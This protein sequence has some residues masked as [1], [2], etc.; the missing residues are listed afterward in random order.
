MLINC[1]DCVAGYLAG[2]VTLKSVGP[3][4]LCPRLRRRS[5]FAVPSQML[6]MATEPGESLVKDSATECK[7]GDAMVQTRSH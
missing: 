3:I 6:K 5:R 1:T 2:N 4:L 7:I